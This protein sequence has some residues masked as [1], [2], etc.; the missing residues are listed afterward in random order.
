M[1]GEE[2][3]LGEPR[4]PNASVKPPFLLSVSHFLWE[5]ESDR[6]PLLCHTHGSVAL[7]VEGPKLGTAATSTGLRPTLDKDGCQT[8]KPLTPPATRAAADMAHLR[9]AR[10]VARTKAWPDWPQGRLLRQPIGCLRFPLVPPTLRLVL[11][12]VLELYLDLLSQPC[13]AVYI[14]VKKNNIPFMMKPV[15][16]LKGGGGGSS[17]VAPFSP[18]PLLLPNLL[19]APHLQEVSEVTGRTGRTSAGLFPVGGTGFVP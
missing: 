4:P 9:A 11:R 10:Q 15:D 19:E 8:P 18:A 1:A 13:R 17:P 16:M 12:M 5:G 7:A 14:F 6:L 2:F 3:A